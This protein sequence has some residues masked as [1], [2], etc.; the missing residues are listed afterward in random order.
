MQQTEFRI[1]KNREGEFYT[2]EDDWS[3]YIS[4]A[5]IFETGAEAFE[6]F[7]AGLMPEGTQIK[8]VYL[9]EIYVL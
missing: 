3:S 4:H 9:A 1:I 7:K 2:R 8:T 5:A 6:T